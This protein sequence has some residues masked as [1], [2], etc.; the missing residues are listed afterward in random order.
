MC[1]DYLEMC[2]GIW[3][4][5]SGSARR[6]GV[7][8][9]LVD[10]PAFLG[11]GLPSSVPSALASAGWTPCTP[12]PAAT[13]WPERWDQAGH[14]RTQRPDPSPHFAGTIGSLAADG[15]IALTGTSMVALH[16]ATVCRGVG[17][18]GRP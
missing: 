18:F 1:G 15:Y 9:C 6:V 11:C 3:R 17:W 14:H 12:A 13:L 2:G 16:V 4:H 10:C 8:D 5:V 7:D